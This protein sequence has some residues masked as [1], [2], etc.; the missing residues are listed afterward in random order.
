MKSCT[1][2]LE[3][4][5]KFANS[6]TKCPLSS[7]TTHLR[8]ENPKPLYA[9]QSLKIYILHFI[10]IFSR[11]TEGKHLFSVEEAA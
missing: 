3:E 6:E 7:I 10:P 1:G 2:W 9:L 8:N 11:Y 5:C 4:K